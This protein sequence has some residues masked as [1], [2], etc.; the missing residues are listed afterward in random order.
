MY[1]IIILFIGCVN[2]WKYQFVDI[3]ENKKYLGKYIKSNNE[4]FHFNFY[5]E[6]KLNKNNGIFGIV[7]NDILNTEFIGEGIVVESVES[8]DIPNGCSYCKY[9][10]VLSF[11]DSGAN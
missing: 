9:Y 11:Y 4:Q 1:K 10:H 7:T 8:I 2:A 6:T 3:S 5:G